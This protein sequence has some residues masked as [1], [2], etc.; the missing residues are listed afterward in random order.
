MVRKR[1]SIMF[2]L[3]QLR[4]LVVNLWNTLEARKG[5]SHQVWIHSLINRYCSL[6]FMPL[7]PEQSG[8]LRLLHFQ[9]RPNPDKV[10]SN[11]QTAK[12]CFQWVNSLKH[13]VTISNLF[14]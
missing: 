6:T 11:V 2:Y 4:A 3:L 14:M 9:L 1:K 13:V 7:E 10:S 12:T 5:K 8:V